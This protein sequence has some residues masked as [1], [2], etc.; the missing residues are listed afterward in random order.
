MGATGKQDDYLFI[1]ADSLYTYYV[2]SKPRLQVFGKQT[3]SQ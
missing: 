1:W 3:N 2:P